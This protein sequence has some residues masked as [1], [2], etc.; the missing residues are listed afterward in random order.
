[1]HHFSSFFFFCAP[2]QVLRIF[3]VL[4]CPK[5][6]QQDAETQNRKSAHARSPAHAPASTLYAIMHLNT[7]KSGTNIAWPS[8]QRETIVDARIFHFAIEPSICHST[9][10]ALLPCLALT[11]TP[12]GYFFSAV[13]YPTP[14]ECSCC[15]F[16]NKA[17]EGALSVACAMSHLKKG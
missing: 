13:V 9:T 10:L 11:D 8:Q 1:M 15:L 6:R 4:L 17:Q 14:S 2:A 12:F 3:S 16:L 7:N 5:N